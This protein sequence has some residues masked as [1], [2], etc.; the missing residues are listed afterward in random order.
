MTTNQ[1]NSQ[2]KKPLGKYLVRIIL[3]VIL[4]LNSDFTPIMS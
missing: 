1:Q 4:E 2:M 3:C